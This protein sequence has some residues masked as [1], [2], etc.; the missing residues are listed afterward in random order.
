M[1]S[2]Q[3][4]LPNGAIYALLG[5]ALVLVFA[6]TRVILIPRASSATTRFDLRPLRP[7]V[8]TA[9]A[10][11]WAWWRSARPVPGR[12]HDPAVVGR[13]S[14]QHHPECHLAL[15]SWLAAQTRSHN[16]ALSL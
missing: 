2:L 10:W 13:H 7:P 1:L 9:L 8:R 6:V 3:T 15:T 12:S 4:A 11:R 5:L 14:R 16:I